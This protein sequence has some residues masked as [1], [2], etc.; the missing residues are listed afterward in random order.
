[1]VGVRR[2]RQGKRQNGTGGI[3]DHDPTTVLPRRW[4][5]IPYPLSRPWAMATMDDAGVM[6]DHAPSLL[7]LGVSERA[8][9]MF[10]SLDQV[11]KDQEKEGRD[12]SSTWMRQVGAGGRRYDR[13]T[14]LLAFFLLL[15]RMHS[16]MHDSLFTHEGMILSLGL[17]KQQRCRVRACHSLHRRRALVDRVVRPAGSF[18]VALCRLAHGWPAGREPRT[19]SS[20]RARV[21]LLHRNSNQSMPL[22]VMMTEMSASRALD[23]T[24]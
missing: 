10:L 12:D 22:C 8:S 20:E 1:M 18:L 16:C 2:Q 13:R 23:L 6:N 21:L 17:D 11:D 14:I 7:L 15:G 5:F 9:E 19:T 4:M 3:H 24:A